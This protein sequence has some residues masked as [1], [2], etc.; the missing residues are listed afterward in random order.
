MYSFIYSSLYTYQRNTNML[1]PGQETSKSA[2]LRDFVSSQ[3]EKFIYGSH[4]ET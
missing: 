3:I 4:D 1:C 2:W